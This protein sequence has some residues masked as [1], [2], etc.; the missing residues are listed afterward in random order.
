MSLPNNRRRD[1][2]GASS[3]AVLVW[4]AI[5]GVIVVV[6]GV[7]AAMHLGHRI[8]D[9]GADLPADPFSVLFGLLGGDLAWPGAAGWWVIATLAVVL[10]VLIVAAG[11]LVHRVRARRSRVDRAAR[12]MGRG[13]D[14]QDLTRKQALG[15]ATRLGVNASPGVPIGRTVA[16]NEP[17]YGSWEDMHIDIWGPRT[18]KTTSR[19]VPAILEAPGSVLVTSNKRDVVD[20]TRDVRAQAGPVWVFDPQAII[21][22]EPSWWW[23]P[24]SYVTDEV[25]AAKLA[26]HFATGSRDPG[27]R[28]DAYFDPAGQDL[29]AG[30]LLAAALDHRPITDVYSWLTRP[31]DETA[32][33]ILHEHG[34][35]LTADQVAGV[36]SAPEK[37]RGGVFGT[38]QQMASCLTNRQVARW[39]TPQ[40]VADPRRQFRPEDFVRAD[41]GTLY[42]LSKEGRG[43]AGPLVTALTVA[44][45]EAAEDLA[46]SSRGGRLG[47][48]LLGVLDEAANVCRWRDL[49]NLYSHYG[50][51]GIVLMTILQSWSQGVEVWGQSGMKKLWS[52]SNV[53]VYGGGVSEAAFLE[54]LSRMIGDYDRLSSSTSHGR[55]HRTVSQQLHRERILD[56]ADLAALPKGRAVVMA[57]GSRP[58]LI[59]TQPWMHG[60]HAAEVE[61]SI[62]AHDPQAERTIR[63]AQSAA[64]AVEAAV[65]AGE[66]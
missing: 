60:P 15:T 51:R 3:D 43:T 45:V 2:G 11:L 21:L 19:A 54:D 32:V 6:G 39:V 24:L 4:V 8:A 63:E 27:A 14:V 36:V 18:G 59:R 42:S 13:R 38:A 46:A 48:P 57:S 62:A 26:D 66:V 16:Q 37:Q 64:A 49:P 50:S 35:T 20:A 7:Y 10:V 9:T 52:A 12:Y 17:L 28:T 33:D 55:G 53:K 65:G 23:N 40:G 47:T 41:G 1:P 22:E 29:L 58:T 30:L 56:V 44:V 61:A 5:A 34:Y 25:R 31:T